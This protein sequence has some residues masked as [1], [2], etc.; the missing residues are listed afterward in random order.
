MYLIFIDESGNSLK[1]EA[2]QE[3]QPFYVLSALMIESDEYR[4][5]SKE[6]RDAFSNLEIER[7]E[8][9]IGRGFEIK[10]REVVKGNGWWAKN[11]QIRDSVRDH[12]L[13]FPIKGGGLAF[14][15]VI[16]KKKLSTQYTQPQ[17][18]SQLAI[19]YLF[20][21]LQRALSLKQ[22]IGICIFDQAHKID[23]EMH[24]TTNSLMRDGS[25]LSYLEWDY[26]YVEGMIK[27]NRIIE[28]CLGKSENSLGL[29]VADYFAT[30]AFQYFKSRNEEKC[31]WWET[32]KKSLYKQGNRIDGIGLKIFPK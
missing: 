27:I 22:D 20:E 26:G 19:K 28:F 15:V 25:S 14:L 6:T 12:M 29:Q 4:R 9:P 32:I 24:S 16:D 23:D 7:Y 21:R 13:E 8:Y 17:E 31:L 18:P 5:L 3:Q 11:K 1:W 2:D 30:Y 10:A